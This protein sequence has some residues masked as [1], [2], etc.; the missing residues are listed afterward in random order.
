MVLRLWYFCIVMWFDRELANNIPRISKYLFHVR[1][2]ILI[3]DV[4]CSKGCS[5]HRSPKS[6]Q[7]C[8]S[9]IRL[10][11]CTSSASVLTSVSLWFWPEAC[12]RH[13]A[14]LYVCGRDKNDRRIHVC[15]GFAKI[16]IITENDGTF[17][18]LHLN[19]S[20]GSCTTAGDKNTNMIL[21]RLLNRRK[22][23]WYCLDN[24]Y[25]DLSKYYIN[26]QRNLHGWI[27][28][29]PPFMD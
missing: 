5:Y 9:S 16:H 8:S 14:C 29:S 10:P 17:S 7:D 18:G 2:S 1:L 11:P 3:E 20:K 21:F 25:K 15:E 24:Y 6:G 27:F 28:F 22:I 19:V 12:A 23:R 4:K 13:D 26:S